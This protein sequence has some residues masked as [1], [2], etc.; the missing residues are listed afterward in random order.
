[1]PGYIRSPQKGGKVFLATDS[2]LLGAATR[3][4]PRRLRGHR[5]GRTQWVLLSCT[6]GGRWGE[7]CVFRLVCHHAADQG[8]SAREIYSR[9][10]ACVLVL[11]GNIPLVFSKLLAVF[12]AAD[13]ENRALY[14]INDIGPL[15]YVGGMTLS[16]AQVFRI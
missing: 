9:C 10:R 1:M 15:D 7:R 3:Y 4:G 5:V 6:F 13:D 11:N 2:T 16:Q 12:R 8:A 14:N